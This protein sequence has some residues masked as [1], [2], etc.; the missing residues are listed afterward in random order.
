M[1]PANTSIYD[2]IGGE[3]A[4]VAVVD[5]FYRRVLA[6]QQLAGFFAGTN[7][8]RLKG[9]QVAFFAEALGGPELYDGASIKDAHRGRGITR[10]DFDQVVVH[11]TASLRAAGVPVDMTDQIIGA[12][13]PLAGQI[14]SSGMSGS[15]G[16][17]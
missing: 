4:L 6:D 15:P 17:A 14:I 16:S 11:L 10:A 3:G 2:A 1:D 8:T 13:A 12:I 5:D 7:M 9:R